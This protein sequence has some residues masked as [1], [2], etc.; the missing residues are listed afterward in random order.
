MKEQTKKSS[1][2]IKTAAILFWIAVWQITATAAHNSILIASPAEVVKKLFEL[3]GESETYSVLVRSFG[4][5]L[6]GFFAA[7]ATGIV[8]AAAAQMSGVVYELVTPLMRLIKSVP[9]ASFIIMAL[10]WISSKNLSILISFMIVLPVVYTNIYTGIGSADIKLLEMAEVFEMP[11]YKRLRYIYVPAVYPHF[12]SAV[13]VGMGFCLK[14]GIAAEVIGIPNG[15]VGSRLYEAK[16]YIM[17]GELFAW[18]ILIVFI[19]AALEKTVLKLSESLFSCRIL[20]NGG[21][22]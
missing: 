9:V 17:T 13:S 6:A 7:I 14:S 3:L 2:W 15:T 22:R 10:L 4:H 16:L 12:M 8:L 5:I 19:S 20:K 18:T 21:E 1:K 11:L